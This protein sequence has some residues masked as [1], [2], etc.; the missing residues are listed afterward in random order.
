MEDKAEQ[1]RVPASS[2][3]DNRH[4]AKPVLMLRGGRVEVVQRKLQ[5]FLDKTKEEKQRVTDLDLDDPSPIQL[6]QTREPSLTPEQLLVLCKSLRGSDVQKLT[7][8][9]CMLGDEGLEVLITC[10]ASDRDIKLESLD[11]YCNNLTPKGIQMLTD[12]LRDP[13]C[14]PSLSKIF[15]CEATEEVMME[16]L[17][18]LYRVCLARPASLP[19]VV[20]ELDSLAPPAKNASVLKRLHRLQKESDLHGQL[21][22]KQREIGR[23]ENIL[24]RYP[25]KKVCDPGL[26]RIA[27]LVADPDLKGIGSEGKATALQLQQSLKE[28]L[29]ALGF[30]CQ[31]FPD[32]TAR[33]DTDYRVSLINALKTTL[34]A[35]SDQKKIL[36]FHYLGHGS[37]VHST[38]VI[39]IRDRELH[40]GPIYQAMQGW[41]GQR[42]ASNIIITDSC[43]VPPAIR[44]DK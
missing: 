4:Q 35:L 28:R 20:F 19:T 5:A 18:D 41:N 2:I 40:L 27:F 39:Q 12:A 37:L 15:L 13:Q 32:P 16:A 34:P 21:A 42:G 29:E 8:Q 10:F 23:L 38:P 43:L 44:S 36:L 6:G 11:L 3:V 24:K 33:G 30:A 14:M 1:P 26:P 31:I 17:V 25:D 7:L 22:K 9:Y